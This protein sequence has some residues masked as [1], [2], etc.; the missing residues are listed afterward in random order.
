MKAVCTSGKNKR[1]SKL[2]EREWNFSDRDK[3]PDDE[4]G[5]CCYWEYGRESK[6]L[7]ELAG[8]VRD[9]RSL[10]PQQAQRMHSELGRLFTIGRPGELFRTMASEFP[11]P[12]QSLTP[13]Q[14]KQGADF[15]PQKNNRF[16]S[17]LPMPDK[18]APFTAK[19][20]LGDVAW[21]NGQ[22]QRIYEEDKTKP[23]QLLHS[24]AV[25]LE[26]IEHK[27][28]AIY[29]R[30]G[31]ETLVAKIGWREFSNKEIADAFRKWVFENRP[32][33]MPESPRRGHQVDEWRARLERLGLLRLRHALS[34]EE[35]I[36]AITQT[37]PSVKRKATK[38]HEPGVLNQ[39][40]EKAIDNFHK[41]FP[42]LDNAEKPL[43]HSMK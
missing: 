30:D 35:T 29:P 32:K 27:I 4:L 11:K 43:C 33:E 21:L 20:T 2:D 10:S 36:Q 26:R 34:V 9:R 42:F 28:S 24:K 19:A 37:L 22:A 14:R 25:E 40:A 17:E 39:E 31:I 41:L 6:S 23:P 5:A 18:F 1:A 16:L 8:L 38:F 13:E 15:A 12:W 3:V 7:R